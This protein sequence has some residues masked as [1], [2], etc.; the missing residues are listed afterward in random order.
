MDSQRKFLGKRIQELRK[1]AG[2]TQEDL[3]RKASF[4][5]HQIVSQIE[6][7]ERD[8]KAWELDR[9]SRALRVKL[10]DILSSNK[11]KSL[12]AVLW[13]KAPESQQKELES[14]FLQRCERYHQLEQRIG[15]RSFESLP[16]ITDVDP[17]SLDFPEV[18][19]FADQVR[20]QLNLGSRPATSLVKVLE[21]T[22]GVKIFYRDLGK[23][24][25]AAS[26]IGDFGIGILMN[27]SEAPWRRNYNFAHELFHILTWDV[28]PPALLHSGSI[29]AKKIEALANSFASN[30]LVPADSIVSEF[31]KRVKG[32]K[33]AYSALIEIAREFDVSSEAL[34]W[35]L[36]IL[37]RLKSKTV[38]DLIKDSKFH[39][40]DK[41]TM[42]ERWWHPTCL[43]ERY[44]RLAFF[45]YQK[46]FM[47]RTLIAEYLET[48]LFD[49]S[50]L[51][52]EYGLDEK[53]NYEAEVPAS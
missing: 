20:N 8:L 5:A 36:K 53:E 1:R 48:S 46:G 42:K 52:M 6:K 33:I 45:A 3:A 13:R 50:D 40:L 17:D 11:I 27:A 16:K 35:R 15:P 24:G 30:L 7:G 41:A 37:R 26:S 43:P 2:L 12:P 47:T 21:E 44:V 22:Y 10:S 32:G 31:D 14:E 34:L 29:Q 28:I 38:E 19:S 4:P 39:E 51:L 18:T 25:S 49:L 9:I 23:E